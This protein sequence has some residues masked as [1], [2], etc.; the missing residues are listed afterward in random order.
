MNKAIIIITFA[1]L[2]G[3]KSTSKV[4]KD[5]PAKSNSSYGDTRTKP[6]QY[7]DDDT[8]LL[9]EFSKDKSYAFNPKNPVKVGGKIDSGVKNERRYLNALIAPNGERVKYHRIGSCCHFKTPNGLFGDGAVLDNYAVY[10]KGCKDT[11]NIYINIYDEGDLF[12]P[13]G[14]E[15]KVSK[16]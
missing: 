12:I 5:T 15:A 8:F 9:V 16:I 11:L 2:I 14:F 4:S 3:C 7:L 6:L 13:V 10:W 1:F